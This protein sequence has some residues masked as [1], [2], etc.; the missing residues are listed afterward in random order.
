MQLRFGWLTI[1][2]ATL[3]L[4]GC[5][6]EDRNPAAD[7]VAT[8]P[9]GKPT[10]QGAP[11][12]AIRVGEAYDFSPSAS[13][14]DG[15]ALSFRIANKPGWASFD[16]ATGRLSGTPGDADVGMTAD[17]RITV[18]DGKEKAA[19]ARFSITVNQISLGSATLSW[20]PPTQNADGTPLIDLS[21]YK[22]YYGRDASTLDQ[23]VTLDNPGL[24]RFVIENLSPATWFF[25]MTSV[26]SQGVESN[27]SATASNTVG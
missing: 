14:P 10:I 22:I 11:P 3:M 21:G 20:M 17:V 4:G 1:V 7:P 6:T 26:N 18:S 25:A 19:L 5:F 15:D 24:T 8:Q 13:D 23:V 9:N 16:A 2:F 27:R 12:T